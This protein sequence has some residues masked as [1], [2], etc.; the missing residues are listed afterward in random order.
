MKQTGEALVRGLAHFEFNHAANIIIMKDV[1]RFALGEK[2]E[3]LIEY[4]T[5]NG[6]MTN[7]I[8]IQKDNVESFGF[9]ELQ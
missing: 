9:V 1:V 5:G 2:G 7:A 4:A 6:S 3:Y 8:F